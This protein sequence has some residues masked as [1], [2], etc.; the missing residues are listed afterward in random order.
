MS[1]P[2]VDMEAL[3][4]AWEDD[5]PDN[6]YYLDKESGSVELVQ[7]GLY[8]LRDLTDEIEC[9]RERYL[10]IPKPSPGQL[11]QDL[12]DFVATVTDPQVSRLLDVAMES[13][14]PLQ[15]IKSI[16]SGKPGEVSRWVEFRDGRVRLRVRQWLSANCMAPEREIEDFTPPD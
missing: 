15:A 10:Y 7:Q 9:H 1:K 2:L 16:L 3:I 6:A 11:R 5:S 13:S 4:L 14:T 12:L 8:D